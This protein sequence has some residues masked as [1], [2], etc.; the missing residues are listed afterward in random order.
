MIRVHVGIDDVR[1]SHAFRLRER[2][3]ILVLALFR[4][5]DGAL[6][7]GPTPEHVRRAASSEVVEGSKNHGFSWGVSVSRARAQN[8]LVFY[9]L[10]E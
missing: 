9:R 4:V 7:E 1:D 3:V 2:C 5:H 6:A 10:I 8:D